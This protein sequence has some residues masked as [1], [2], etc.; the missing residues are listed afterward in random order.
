MPFFN[1]SK[2][3]KKAEKSKKVL[4]LEEQIKEI[5]ELNF[6][7]EN[8][9]YMLYQELDKEDKE[10]LQLTKVLDTKRKQLKDEDNKNIQETKLFNKEEDFIRNVKL[11]EKNAVLKTEVK[12]LE[13]SINAL[14][15][16]FKEFETI[17]GKLKKEE[18]DKFELT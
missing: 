8:V 6:D 5:L 13:Q 16:N 12:T 1:N 2:V 3:I 7:L 14:K 4:Q 9:N 10:L 11:I 17:D 18:H 15:L